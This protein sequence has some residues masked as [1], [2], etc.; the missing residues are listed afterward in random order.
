MCVGCFSTDAPFKHA[1][2]VTP[3][4]SPDVD[5]A[6]TM[7]EALELEDCCGYL[8]ESYLAETSPDFFE[9]G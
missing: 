3:N 8:F 6:T 9:V 4:A 1:L 2:E 5:Y 7:P